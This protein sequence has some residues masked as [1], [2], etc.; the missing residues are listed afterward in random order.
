MTGGPGA[1]K[2]AALELIRQ[3]FCTHIYVLHEA[4]GIVF[5]G[6]FPRGEEVEIRRAGQ[7]AIFY[8]Q[9]ELESA[10]NAVNPAVVL[11]DRGTIDGVAYWPG[12]DDLWHSVDTT[13][14][15]Q[16]QRYDAVIHLRTPQ[17]ETGYNRTNPLRV[18]SAAEAKSID[19][20]IA[21]AWSTHPRRF[22]VEPTVEFLSKAA[23]VLDLVRAEV[24]ACCRRHAVP[25]SE[26]GRLNS[27]SL[28]PSHQSPEAGT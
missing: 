14:E 7:R 15:D 9:R 19:E 17:V 23:R 18:E 28:G 16:L 20:R 3:S 6:G 5:G 26:D 11:C 21:I 27:A 24:P 13:L 25:L 4:A 2:T 12:P 1:G 22:V 8:V 10:A